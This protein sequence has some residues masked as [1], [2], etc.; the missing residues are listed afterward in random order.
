MNPLI[1][2]DGLLLLPAY[3][4]K[5]KDFLATTKVHK[6]ARKTFCLGYSINDEL[7]SIDFVISVIDD[8]LR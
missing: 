1:L 6:G 7:S 8:K 5:T 2:T 4:A 3:I